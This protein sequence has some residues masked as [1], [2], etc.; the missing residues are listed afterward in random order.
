MLQSE[1]IDS[2]QYWLN[3]K[4]W[5][6]RSSCQLL[7]KYCVDISTWWN[8]MFFECGII[9]LFMVQNMVVHILS[10]WKCCQVNQTEEL[11]PERWLDFWL[12]WYQIYDNAS[13]RTNFTQ[14]WRPKKMA[15][16]FFNFEQVMCL[17][18]KLASGLHLIEE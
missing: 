12:F 2:R 18:I 3:V 8:A 4:I 9:D 6:T 17:F 16:F 14:F 11:L 15:V 10:W 5:L 1:S 7:E 13:N